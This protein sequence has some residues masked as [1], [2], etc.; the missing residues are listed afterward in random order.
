MYKSIMLAPSTLPNYVQ[1]VMGGASV[2]AKSFMACSYA[3]GTTLTHASV[4]S[5]CV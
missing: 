4:I 2:A 5:V 3:H 1:I